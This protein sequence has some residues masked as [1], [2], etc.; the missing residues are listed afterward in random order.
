MTV[1]SLNIAMGSDCA[2]EFPNEKKPL[3]KEET[4]KTFESILRRVSSV[5]PTEEEGMPL[6]EK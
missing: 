5:N 6:A 1:F 4:K 2:I 3:V